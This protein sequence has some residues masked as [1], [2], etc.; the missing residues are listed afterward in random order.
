MNKCPITLKLKN[1]VG[2]LI[3][4]TGLS[5]CG[6]AMAGH[7]EA[8]KDVSHRPAFSAYHDGVFPKVAPILAGDWSVRPAFPNLVFHNPMGLCPVPGTND[9]IVWEREGR[10]WRFANDPATT[11]KKLVLDLSDRCQGWHDSGLY[12][13]AAAG[14]CLR[15]LRRHEPGD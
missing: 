14:E 12:C 5:L 2:M 1:I 10:V 15:S 13:R 11:E 7:T 9:L 3:T 4:A 6:N 8:T